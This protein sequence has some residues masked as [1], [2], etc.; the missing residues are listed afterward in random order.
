MSITFNRVHRYLLQRRRRPQRRRRYHN[1][2]P[3]RHLRH[4][5]VPP[6]FHRV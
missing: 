3:R 2:P 6:T 4:Q 1:H 5:S